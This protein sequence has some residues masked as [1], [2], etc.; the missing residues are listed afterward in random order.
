MSLEDNTVLMLAER[1][2]RPCLTVRELAEASGHHPETI[3]RW[4]EDGSIRTRRRVR[5]R[6]HWRILRAYAVE[7]IIN[8][9]RKTKKAK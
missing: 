6:E 1:Y 4:C 5:P 8:G 2:P 7:F 3:R 9:R